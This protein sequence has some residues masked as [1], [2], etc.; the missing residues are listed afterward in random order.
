MTSSTIVVHGTVQSGHT[1]R[2]EIFL[3]MLGVPYRLAHSPAD[4]RRT[5]ELKPMPVWP[6]PEPKATT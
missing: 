3:R 5:P 4:V 6:I 1:H 2:V